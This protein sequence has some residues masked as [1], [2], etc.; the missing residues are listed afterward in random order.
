[1]LPP[2]TSAVWDA[3]SSR[4]ELSGF[5]LI[6]CTAL[7]LRIEHRVSEDLYVLFKDHGFTARDYLEVFEKAG[8]SHAFEIGMARLCSGNPELSDEGYAALASNP[9]SLDQMRDFFLAMRDEL[10]VDVAHRAFRG[11]PGT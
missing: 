3:L 7:S 10:E 6:G 4:S 11:R 9:P 8:E 2:A 1:V 5:I